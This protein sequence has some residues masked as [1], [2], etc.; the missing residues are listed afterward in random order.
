M[1][2][3][4]F[5]FFSAC[6]DKCNI[7]ICI[8]CAKTVDHCILCQKKFPQFMLKIIK[9]NNLEES[10]YRQHPR[11]EEYYISPNIIPSAPHIKNL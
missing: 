3:I 11:I 10:V 8:K 2:K 6:P 9:L 7:S 1:C 4:R 5:P